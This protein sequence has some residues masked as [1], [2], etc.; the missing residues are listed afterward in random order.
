LSK[1]CFSKNIIII[2]IIIINVKINVTQDRKLQGHSPCIGSVC[3]T[4]VL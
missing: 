2:I 3:L 4:D 1:Q